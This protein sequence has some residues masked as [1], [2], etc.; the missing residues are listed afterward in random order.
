MEIAA[1]CKYELGARSKHTRVFES[2]CANGVRHTHPVGVEYEPELNGTFI[3]CT[4]ASENID[5]DLITDNRAEK[6]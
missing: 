6:G 2:Y 1:R 4:P 3:Y 5:V